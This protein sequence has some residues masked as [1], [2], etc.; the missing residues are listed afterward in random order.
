MFLMQK[1][2]QAACLNLQSRHEG[3]LLDEGFIED[4]RHMEMQ[5][6]MTEFFTLQGKVELLVNILFGSPF[7]LRLSFL[8]FFI[9]WK[10]LGRTRR[11]HLKVM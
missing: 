1:N 9:P 3:K 2:K 8:G 7:H 10:K 5:G 11:I 6:L 4:F